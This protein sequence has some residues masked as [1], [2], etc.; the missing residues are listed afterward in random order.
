MLE[1]ERAGERKREGGSGI[2][3]KVE[4]KKKERMEIQGYTCVVDKKQERKKK[5]MDE[6]KEI[7][8]QYFHNKF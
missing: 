7:Q 4:K 8:P 2:K 5:H 3:W 1:N 6:R